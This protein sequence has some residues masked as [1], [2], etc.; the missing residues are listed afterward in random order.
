MKISEPKDNVWWVDL[1]SRMGSVV[2]L[3]T[4]MMK[5]PNKV[6]R[7]YSYFDMAFNLTKDMMAK[8]GY[9]SMM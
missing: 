5:G 6:I 4:H 2:G 8:H 9:Y 7:Y 3:S 1:L